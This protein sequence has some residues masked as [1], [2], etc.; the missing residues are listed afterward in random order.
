MTS[1]DL[2]SHYV[3]LNY[4]GDFRE[5]YHRLANGGAE[6]YFAQ[7]YSLDSVEGLLDRFGNVTVIVCTTEERYDEVLPNGVRS[8]GLG[9]KEPIGLADIAPTILALQPTHLMICH[10]LPALLAWATKLPAQLSII[11]A[12]S[13]KRQPGFKG[14]LKAWR[15]RRLLNNPRFPWIGAY[16]MS[17]ARSFAEIGV[18]PGK[19]V[20][21]DFLI[22]TE[23]A[24]F[25][26]VDPPG[27]RRKKL[28][29]VGQLVESKGVPEVIAA[30]AQLRGHGMDVSLTLV[31]REQDNSLRDLARGLDVS[32]QVHFVGMVANDRIEAVMRD[33]D[34]VIVP[35]R[36]DYPEGF[37]LVLVHALRAR[38][39]IVASDHP[40]FLEA[41][42]HGKDA[43]IFPAQQIEALTK[44]IETL[45]SD[46]ALYRALSEGSLQVI[47]RLRVE[48]HYA[49]VLQSTFDLDGPSKE[50]LKSNC[51]ARMTA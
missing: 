45:F 43:V 28:L 35:S 49:D 7:R 18:D 50:R 24:P 30:L 10:L 21:W 20:P 5:A 2:Q 6:T 40:S 12:N 13:T 42:R 11:T 31:G 9:L 19:I 38:I 51:L 4:A 32:E 17:G 22:E 1:P 44:A 3:L 29:Y 15:L 34:A 37:P 8:I 25:V 27:D 26:P 23:T 39:P 16:S 46:A 36:H 41:L 33:H 14:W 47:D 48:L